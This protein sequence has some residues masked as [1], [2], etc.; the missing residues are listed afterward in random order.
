MF[1]QEAQVLKCLN[2]AALKCRMVD[3]KLD[4]ERNKKERK[5]K[6]DIRVCCGLC[7]VIGAFLKLEINNTV[8]VLITQWK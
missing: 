4:G 8:M 2:S 1:S 6:S 3:E 5:H 7:F